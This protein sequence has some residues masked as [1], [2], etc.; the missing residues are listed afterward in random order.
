M[1]RN[2]LNRIPDRLPDELTEILAESRGVKIERIVSRGHCSQP[3]FWYDQPENEFILLLHGAARLLFEGDDQPVRLK[4]G[5][6]LNIPPG[7]RHRV[8]WTEPGQ[9]TVWLAVYFP[10]TASPA[11]P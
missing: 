11:E 6:C 5:D 1:K 7:R 10:T 8:E 9:N 2:L 4:A 3:G